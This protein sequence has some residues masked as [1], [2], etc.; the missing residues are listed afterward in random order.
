MR[1]DAIIATAFAD[2][3]GSA[4]RIGTLN[5][6]PDLLG[7]LLSAGGSERTTRR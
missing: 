6:S 1:P 3:A 5:I 4:E 2:L 7:Q